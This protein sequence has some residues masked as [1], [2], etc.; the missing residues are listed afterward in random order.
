MRKEHRDQAGPSTST[1]GERPKEVLYLDPPSPLD[2]DCPDAINLS[3][4]DLFDYGQDFILEDQSSNRPENINLDPAP[5]DIR[6]EEQQADDGQQFILL[7]P[8]PSTS[9]NSDLMSTDK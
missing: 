8:G 4:E 5:E 3:N 2:V 6:L 1:R 9:N 7:Q